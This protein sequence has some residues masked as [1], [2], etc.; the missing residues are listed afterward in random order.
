MRCLGL[1]LGDR[2]TRFDDL[3]F[4]LGKRVLKPDPP[5]NGFAL[6]SAGARIDRS[7]GIEPLDTR[8]IG[9]RQPQRIGAQTFRQ[10]FQLAEVAASLF[11]L[12][13]VQTKKVL[14]HAHS[15]LSRGVSGVPS[16]TA[17]PN[18][19]Y[20]AKIPLSDGEKANCILRDKLLLTASGKHV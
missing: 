12:P 9:G 4:D 7:V 6:E 13:A 20:S 5:L 8:V 19:P 16:R 10:R 1:S 11:K 18:W 17:Y 15:V 2:P 3:S 14:D